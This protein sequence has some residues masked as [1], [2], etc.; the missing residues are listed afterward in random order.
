[1]GLRLSIR[2]YH[3]CMIL[4]PPSQKQTL[5]RILPPVWLLLCLMFLYLKRLLG[6]D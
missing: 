2:H 3:Q 5:H 1:M 4:P 6:Q